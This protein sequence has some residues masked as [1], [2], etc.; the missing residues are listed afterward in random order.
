VVKFLLDATDIDLKSDLGGAL[1]LNAA[2]HLNLE[3]IDLL[4][5]RA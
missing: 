5:T 2:S 4:I 3:M 1:L